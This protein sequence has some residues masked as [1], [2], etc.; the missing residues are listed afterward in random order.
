MPPQDFP[1]HRLSYRQLL[2][3]ITQAGVLQVRLSLPMPLCYKTGLTLLK[4]MS[5]EA[6]VMLMQH[7]KPMSGRLSKGQKCIAWLALAALH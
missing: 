3:M 7:R 6:T 2:K 1:C 5:T 4:L